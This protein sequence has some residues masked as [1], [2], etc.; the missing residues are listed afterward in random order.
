MNLIRL[1]VCLGTLIEHYSVRMRFIEKNCGTI[2]GNELTPYKMLTTPTSTKFIHITYTYGFR[3]AKLSH[4][5]TAQDASESEKRDWMNA[6]ATKRKQQTRTS[7][8]VNFLNTGKP[9]YNYYY[10]C[11]IYIDIYIFVII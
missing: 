10:V 9:L 1:L 8:G 2:S 3:F 4:F 7:G 6:L 5:L 11:T